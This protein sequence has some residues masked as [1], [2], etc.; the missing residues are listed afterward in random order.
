M[1]RLLTLKTAWLMDTVGNKHARVEIAAIKVAAPQ[2]ALKIIDR[3]IQV[4]GGG[5]VTDD[6][7]LAKVC[8][9]QRTLRLADGPD[10]VHKRTI[11]Q[12]ELRRWAGSPSRGARWRC[13]EMAGELTGRTAIVTGASRGI[14]LA[15]AEALRRS[16]ARNVVLTSRTA[17]A[18]EAAA[19]A[20]D[21]ERAAGY[22][23]HAADE[24]A[25][26]AASRSRSSASAA[27]TSSSTTPAPTRRSGRWSTRTTRASPRRSTSTCGRR[28]CG[29]RLAWR[30]VDG[31]ARRRRGQHR[32][33]R[34]ARPSSPNLGIYNVTKAALIHLTR[35]LALEL[36]PKV[37]VNAV[38]PG[39]VRTRLSEVLWKDHEDEV[40]GAHAA[41]PDRRT[42]RRRRRGRVP[43]LRSARAGSPARRW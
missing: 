19:A 33:A 30:G 43:G 25:A 37:R 2:M 4:H 38:A 17:E 31:R 13:A 15:V 8:A 16:A 10:E 41:G 36:A 9:H 42:R 29:P 27:S 24:E 12:R 40:A 5:G 7:P 39:V 26:A 23:A 32:L 6:F 20:L 34:R 3:A 14:G 21:R 22:A 18:A 1:I 28:S 35:Q 11:A